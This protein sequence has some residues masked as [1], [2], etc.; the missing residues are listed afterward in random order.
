MLVCSWL[1]AFWN[2]LCSP[3]TSNFKSATRLSMAA[4]LFAAAFEPFPV[5]P[6]DPPL[7]LWPPDPPCCESVSECK[8][9]VIFA[10][11]ES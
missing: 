10:G 1:V 2:R 7:V 3:L 9:S 6:G 5:D 11:C 8:V 4:V